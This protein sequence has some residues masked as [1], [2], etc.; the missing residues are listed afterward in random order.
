M[1]NDSDHAFNEIHSWLQEGRLICVSELS[2]VALESISDQTAPPAVINLF[3]Q[4]A[5]A[6]DA[7]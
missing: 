4:H 3:Y 7:E 1:Y 2:L 5:A 6:N